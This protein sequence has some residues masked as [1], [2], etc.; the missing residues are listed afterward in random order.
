MLHLQDYG[1]SESEEEQADAD[2]MNLHLKSSASSTSLMVVNS[3]PV[4][5]SK[6]ITFMGR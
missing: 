2:E 4:V 5:T 1:D 6:P 3:A